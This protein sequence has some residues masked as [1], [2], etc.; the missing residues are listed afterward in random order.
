MSKQIKNG[1]EAKAAIKAGVDKVANVV[2]VT[3]GPAGK[4]VIL[5][6]GFG[7][8]TVSDDGVTVAKDIELEDKFENVGASLIQEV[9]N[10][11]NEEAGDGTTTA[12]VLAQKMIE[13]AFAA[14]T[15][16]SG[17]AHQIKKGMDKAV[18]F[19]VSQLRGLKKD[20]KNKA[21]VEQV[22]TIASLDPEV[23]KLIAEAME[24]VGHDGVITVEEGQTIGLEKE[25]VKG[26]RFD[27][28]F[29]SPYMVTNAERMEAVWEDAAILVTDQKIS[30]VQEI[31]P[32]LESLAQGGRK[33]MVIIAD[34]IEGEALATFILNK[35][36]GTFNVLAVKAPG[37]GDRRKEMLQDIAVLTGAQVISEDLGLKLANATAEHLGSARKIIATREHTTIVDGGG[38]KKKITE[39]IA[40]IRNEFEN[41]SSEFDKEKLQERLAKL[42]GGV[43]VIKVGAFTETEMKAKKFKI[44][45]ALNATKAAVQEGII[46]GG[47]AAFVKVAPLLDG[48]LKK[49]S[50]TAAET[51]GVR[52]IRQALEAPLRQIAENAGVEPTGIIAEIQNSDADH[53]GYDFTKYDAS[54]WKKGL[55]TDMMK[56][57][58]VDPLKV[59]RLALE[60]AVSIASTLVT[61]E[62][63][64]VDKPEP[65]TQGPTPPGMGGMDY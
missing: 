43:G 30:A 42:A 18:A 1:Y 8:P 34:D 38:D 19:V 27:K 23:G 61:S 50:L 51:A 14:A 37:F 4:S 65:K 12:T 13:E 26:M 2:K 52:I 56:A 32:I 46:A 40:Q 55:E 22:A 5:D 41:S 21:E 6:R 33:N 3:L 64:V 45:D 29:V 16:A 17:Q 24:E 9:A 20:I 48:F 54:E 44:E 53:A 31:L 57:G 39:R 60:N 36:R 25:V 49:E 35:I 63:I 10:R 28:G 15:L 7:S 58:I 59:A 47:G 11:T 62:A